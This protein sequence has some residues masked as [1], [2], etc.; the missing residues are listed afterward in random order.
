VIRKINK[1]IYAT[2]TVL[3]TLEIKGLIEETLGE[4]Y[5]K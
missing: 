2:Q 4:L 1:P 5:L 3:A